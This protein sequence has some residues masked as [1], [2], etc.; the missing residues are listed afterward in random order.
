MM[1]MVMWWANKQLTRGITTDDWMS[2]IDLTFDKKKETKI[3]W[4]GGKWNK[5]DKLGTCVKFGI[6]AKDKIPTF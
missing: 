5:N 6:L 2:E 3:K 4:G 1:L